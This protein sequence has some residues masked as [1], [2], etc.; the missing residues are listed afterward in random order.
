MPRVRFIYDYDHDVTPQQ[1]IAYQRG[2]EY[3]VKGEW[4][5]KYIK[6]GVAEEVK[7]GRGKI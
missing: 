7:D 3:L 1:T 6:E 4:A 5:K 2:K